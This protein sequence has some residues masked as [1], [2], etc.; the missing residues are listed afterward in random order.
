[1]TL[2]CLLR[3]LLFSC[4]FLYKNE[5]WKE[6]FQ[7]EESVNPQ[8]MPH[9]W[10]ASLSSL[11]A[12]LLIPLNS[13]SLVTS[14]PQLNLILL[15]PVSF[16]PM[17]DGNIIKCYYKYVFISLSNLKG[18]KKGSYMLYM[19]VYFYYLKWKHHYE[20]D[21]VESKTEEWGEWKK[22]WKLSI[23]FS[24]ISI[25]LHRATSVNILVKTVYTSYMNKTFGLIL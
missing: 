1:M 19:Q 15:L 2:F 16:D 4:C 6:N 9:S 25:S 10:L 18:K 3:Y 22:R 14:S 23:N 24:I 7:I 12:P 5:L 17:P 21:V 11:K 20:S 8:S 13:H